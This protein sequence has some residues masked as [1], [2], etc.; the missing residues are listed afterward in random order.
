MIDSE[1]CSMNDLTI[2][3]ENRIIEFR[4]DEELLYSIER[5][6]S[7]LCDTSPYKIL[8]LK[9]KKLDDEQIEE[10]IK[11]WDIIK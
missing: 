2:T 7:W 8:Y 6:E 10:A 5:L 1:Q 9:N 4:S 3:F 11:N